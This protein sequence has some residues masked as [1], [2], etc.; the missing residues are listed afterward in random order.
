MLDHTLFFDAHLAGK[1]NITWAEFIRSSAEKYLNRTEDIRVLDVGCGETCP[2]TILLTAR[3]W[4]CTGIDLEPVWRI[5]PSAA[6]SYAAK[7][8]GVRGIIK[9]LVREVTVVNRTQ[10]SILSMAGIKMPRTLDVQCASVSETSF[11]DAEFDVICSKAVFEHVM[12]MK[13][14]VEEMYR[15]TKPGGIGMHWIHLFTSLSGGHDPAW[16]KPDTKP[17]K[18]VPPWDHLLRG[19]SPAMNILN[20]LRERDYR[21][22]L[23]DH[24][25]ILEWKK[26]RQGEKVLTPELRKALKDY[27]EDEL[28]TYG[29][30]AVVRKPTG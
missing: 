15:M 25:E 2:I 21:S 24:F 23:E 20:H 28:L 22:L 26:D 6:L 10:K 3:G 16:A 13:S 27:D 8:G 4:R 14:A 19:R 1:Y 5:S 18:E 7:N 30:I 11:P 29:I 17:S 12:D 9:K